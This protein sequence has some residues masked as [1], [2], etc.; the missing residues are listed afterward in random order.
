MPG[1]FATVLFCL[2][3]SIT[4]N[5][6]LS[7][8][9]AP[10]NPDFIKY[11]KEKKSKR[12]AAVISNETTGYRP[13]FT[14]L[15]EFY[16]E[17][18]IQS[19][20][21]PTLP[22]NFDLR[23]V[24]NYK[25]EK[26]NYVS[27]VKNQGTGQN[28]GN[29]WAFSSLGS[30]ES[31]W[32]WGKG[33]SEQD[34]SEHNIASCHGYA[35]KYGD[36]GN[37]YFSMGYLSRLQGPI[38]ESDDPYDPS[39]SVVCEEGKKPI[40]YT[41]DARWIYN[42]PVMVKKT[43]LDYGPVST[44][45]HWDHSCYNSAKN[46]FSSDSREGPNHAILLVGWDDNKETHKGKGAWIAKNS[47]GP[48]WGSNGFF[49]I[50][51]RD[52]HILKPA[53]FFPE[54]WSK[55][56]IDTAYF[57]DEI[58]T[59]SFM[60]YDNDT[61]YTLSKFFSDKNRLIREVGTFITRTGS[62]VNIQV[63]GEFKNG[64]LSKLLGEASSEPTQC[65][66]FYT[67]NVNAKVNGE[68]F[69]KIKYVTPGFKYP[70]PIEMYAESDGELYANPKIELSGK[71]WVSKDG[72]KWDTLG[73]DK[74]DWEADLVVKVYT[75]DNTSIM[76]DISASKYEVC[77]GSDI[78]FSAIDTSTVNTYTWYFDQFATPKTA[79]GKGPHKIK[80]DALGNDLQ[81]I[82][83]AI[84]YAK[85]VI[86]GP[87]G[88]DSIY[89]EFKIVN[90]LNVQI[91][92]ADYTKINEPIVLSAICD[93][94]AY[95]WYPSTF[96]S[97][98]TSK[99]VTFKSDL[100]GLHKLTVTATQG[101][102]TSTWSTN[103]EVKNPP[104]NDKSCNAIMLKMGDNG[105]FTNDGATAEFKEPAPA[106]TS[107]YDDKTWCDEGGVQN[108]VWFKIVGPKSGKLTIDTRGMDTQIALY[109]ST[110]CNNIKI[111]DLITANDDYYMSAPFAAAIDTVKITPEKEYFL[112]VDGSA[113][114]VTGIFYIKLSTLPLDKLADDTVATTKSSLAV[115][116]NPNYGTM[117]VSYNS[118]K[119]ENI[120]VYISDL[121]GRTVYKNSFLKESGTFDIPVNLTTIKK[122]IYYISVKGSNNTDYTKCI[123]K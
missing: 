105:P 36:G 115:F 57:Y 52:K 86:S 60:G 76:A 38:L 74:K 16:I 101:N 61:A 42:N 18:K 25:N 20:M 48:G 9:V 92:A 104:I 100:A 54:V 56:Y 28:G 77:T 63:F 90:S 103:I 107:C 21:V 5:G 78:V 34:L 111:E 41:P 108:S 75:T 35:W 121:M 50:S 15:P 27:K 69:V 83:Y 98:A 82:G 117:T 72:I 31:I 8:H 116:P 32:M 80:M 106:D 114:G 1:K 71:Q 53:S 109:E 123:I 39:G 66:G 84:K 3:I 55:S 44:N 120:Q 91:G 64:Q 17:N 89:K 110:D 4:L 99:S 122:G 45:I 87:N 33:S 24:P 73:S 58:G 30:V 14:Q 118:E 26:I 102:C 96:L 19:E 59:V 67:F 40:A 23:E 79:S 97:D 47:W 93:A 2:A 10:V 112:Q 95:Q 11:A 51:Y 7:K 68:F 12:K 49:Y 6:Q 119:S 46:T 22:A 94:E 81:D 62:T 85:L 70:V 65:P 88:K 43:I 13:P 113:G 29:C 37:E